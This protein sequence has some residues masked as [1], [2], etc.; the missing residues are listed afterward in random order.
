V[1]KQHPLFEFAPIRSVSD[2]VEAKLLLRIELA[3][4]IKQDRCTLEDEETF[5]AA[6]AAGRGLVPESRDTS[7]RVELEVPWF[8][9]FVCSCTTE[10]EEGERN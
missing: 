2:R 7:V 1:D 5:V 6:R 10:Y 4:E 3:C 8:L 9:L